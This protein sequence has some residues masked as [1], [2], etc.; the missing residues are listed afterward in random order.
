M[1]EQPEDT[2][3][4]VCVVEDD[5]DIRTVVRLLLEEEGYQVL[6]AANGVDGLALLQASP[7]R[8]VAVVDHRL[9]AMDGCDLLEI[10]AQDAAL[11]AQHAFILLTASPRQAEEDCGETLEDL[12]APVVAKPFNIDEIVDAVAEAV[13]R[14]AVR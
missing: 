12:G 2:T 6:E 11:R 8:L 7:K 14:I 9:P 1:L 10:V 5:E 13:Q 4:T 3:A